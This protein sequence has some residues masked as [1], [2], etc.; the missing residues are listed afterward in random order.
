MFKGHR[1]LQICLVQAK[2][3]LMYFHHRGKY[4]N[5]DKDPGRELI[6]QT[7]RVNKCK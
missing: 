5:Y 1:W 2:I 3:V 4:I 7:I 6:N